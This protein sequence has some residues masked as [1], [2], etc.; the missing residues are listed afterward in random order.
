[1]IFRCFKKLQC[2]IFQRHKVWSD[3]SVV[4]CLGVCPFRKDISFIEKGVLLER[5]LVQLA[6]DTEWRI[7]R[8]LYKSLKRIEYPSILPCLI[9][10]LHTTFSVSSYLYESILFAYKTSSMEGNKIVILIKLIVRYTGLE[11]NSFNSVCK[12]I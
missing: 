10:I 2:I 9:W 8:P 1:M 12:C 7:D 4:Y 5:E 3:S 6:M 11:F